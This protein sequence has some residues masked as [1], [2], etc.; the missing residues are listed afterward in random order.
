MRRCR[1][2]RARY[3]R[4]R[5]WTRRRRSAWCRHRH[6]T[7]PP[8]T[9]R[10]HQRHHTQ[11]SPGSGCSRSRRSRRRRPPLRNR[12]SWGRRRRH[13]GCRPPAR[14]R[15]RRSRCRYSTS[16]RMSPPSSTQRI[17][18]QTRPG[19]QL[20]PSPHMQL[21]LPAVQPWV[22]LPSP[23]SLAVVSAVVGWHAAPAINPK[24]SPRPHRSRGIRVTAAVFQKPRATINAR[25]RARRRTAAG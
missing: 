9:R 8:C 1:I 6:P 10:R 18:A 15:S 12:A 17:E 20:S 5:C 14:T 11:G 2:R 16:P 23:V 19:S 25:F 22:S 3:N 24:P 21:R 7:A 13:W 4:C